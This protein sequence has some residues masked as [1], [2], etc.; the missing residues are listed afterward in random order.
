[1]SYK[2]PASTTPLKSEIETELKGLGIDLS[3]ERISKENKVGTY[4]KDL[5]LK[6]KDALDKYSN[7][8]FTVDEGVFTITS[9]TA[10]E[11]LNVTLAGDEKTYNGKW[12]LVKATVLLDG[13]ALGDGEYEIIYYDSDGNVVLPQEAGRKNAGE[14]TFYCEVKVE[15]Y[16]NSAVSEKATVK[17][18]PKEVEVQV[19]PTGKIYGA[20]DPI[21]DNTSGYAGHSK[22]ESE[23]LAENTNGGYQ[24]L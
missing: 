4:T 17:I 9:N 23:Q 8:S 7:Y 16:E 14:S 12:H 11:V 6:N 15:G 24:C 19:T 2:G 1:M 5:T 18:E 20:D 3:V 21:G 22:I 13:K 10:K